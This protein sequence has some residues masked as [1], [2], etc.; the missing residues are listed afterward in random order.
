MNINKNAII[1]LYLYSLYDAF[2][3]PSIT[4]GLIVGYLK[5]NASF[6]VSSYRL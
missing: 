4:K 2:S 6:R 3:K 1:G 5:A